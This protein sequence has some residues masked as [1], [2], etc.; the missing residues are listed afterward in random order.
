[1]HLKEL[2]IRGFQGVTEARLT[3][4]QTGG[5]TIEAANGDF[6]SAANSSEFVLEALDWV[7][8]GRLLPGRSTGEGCSGELEFGEFAV[9][10]KT[11]PE[12]PG[13]MLRLFKYSSNPY[14]C[15]ATVKD[16]TAKT[17]EETQKEI[18]NVIAIHYI[19]GLEQLEGD[20]R[21]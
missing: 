19:S 3:F 4:G 2:R 9:H 20:N 7:L 5:V 18:V 16:L 14:A 10:R 8:F 11:I 15:A 21:N 13:M 6:P 12:A 1:M 17:L